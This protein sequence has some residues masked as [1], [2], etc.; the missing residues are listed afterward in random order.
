[1]G[2][3]LFSVTGVVFVMSIEDFGTPAALAALAAR[4]GFE[5]LVDRHLY[6]PVGLAD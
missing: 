1:M 6:A 3:F 4:T 5:V 2:R